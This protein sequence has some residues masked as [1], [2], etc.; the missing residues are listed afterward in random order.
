[1]DK[2]IICFAFIFFASGFSSANAAFVIKLTNGNEF[3]TVR[4]WQDKEQILFDSYGGIFGIDKGLIASIEQS[5]KTI[6]LT[7]AIPDGRNEQ[8]DAAVNANGGTKA[9]VKSDGR[10]QTK[11]DENDPVK[12]TFASLKEKLKGIDGMLTSEIRALLYEITAFKNMISKNSKYF[13]E[14]GRE[15]NDAQEMGSVVET[16]LRSKDQ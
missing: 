11:Q 9:G 15:F 13:V 3:V 12:K 16:A 5:N 14:Y 7:S 4:Y 10:P 6:N 8:S 1:M 2:S